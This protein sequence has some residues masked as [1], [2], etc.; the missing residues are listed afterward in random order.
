MSA[1]QRVREPPICA[2][3]GSIAITTLAVKICTFCAS[4][5]L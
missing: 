5:N 1:G 3:S 4:A 2:G